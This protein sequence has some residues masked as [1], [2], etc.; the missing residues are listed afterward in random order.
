MAASMMFDGSSATDKEP[1]ENTNTELYI[2][3]V[4]YTTPDGEPQGKRLD[5]QGSASAFLDTHAITGDVMSR[6]WFTYRSGFAPI[7]ERIIDRE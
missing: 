6:F 7:G 5:C 3:G 1:L 2:L 4:K